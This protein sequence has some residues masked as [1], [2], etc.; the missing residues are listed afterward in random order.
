MLSKTE[1]LLAK[2]DAEYGRRS[3]LARVV[4]ISPQI[5]TDWFA[6]RK[7]PTLEQGLAIQGFL[8]KQPRA[9]PRARS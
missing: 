7:T 6:G 9:K 2:I 4:G 1:E 8:K 3:E 5:V